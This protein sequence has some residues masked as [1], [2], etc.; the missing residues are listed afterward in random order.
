[1][2]R[3]HNRRQLLLAAL[4]LVGGTVALAATAGFFY[5][6]PWYVID[7]FDIDAPASVPAW[8]AAM[9]VVVTVVTGL[10]E[11]RRG[12]APGE[13]TDSGVRELFFN[14]GPAASRVIM[15]H[16]RA[17]WAAAWGSALTEIFLFAPHLLFRSVDRLRARVPESRVLERE[18]V[19]LLAE[20]EHEGKWHS[21]SRYGDRFRPLGQLIAMEAIDFSPTKGL[22]CAR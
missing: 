15:L 9:G 3:R 8:S 11:R 18:L 12:R 21:I 14:I 10:F 19:S 17:A 2:I 5:F 16:R 7:R 4:D 1:M 22:V 13:V 20:I 6:V